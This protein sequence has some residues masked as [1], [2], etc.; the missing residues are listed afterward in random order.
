MDG[1]Q[2]RV[3]LRWGGQGTCVNDGVAHSRHRIVGLGG[4]CGVQILR[5]LRLGRKRRRSRIIR[6]IRYIRRVCVWDGREVAVFAELGFW[7]RALGG[8]A[9]WRQRGL[10]TDTDC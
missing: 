5:M 1:G 8:G 10:I 9:D 7:I 4:T 3:G 2:G 6:Y